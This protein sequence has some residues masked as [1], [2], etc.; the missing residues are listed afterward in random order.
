MRDSSQIKGNIE[1]KAGPVNV[2]SEGGYLGYITVIGCLII[3]GM[4]IYFKYGHPAI[5]KRRSRKR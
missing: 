3:V 5:K 1:I 2:K 4:F